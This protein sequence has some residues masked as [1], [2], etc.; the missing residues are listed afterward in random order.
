MNGRKIEGKEKNFIRDVS[1]S[2]ICI[3]LSHQLIITLANYFNIE[4]LITMRCTSLVPS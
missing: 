2:L 4:R 3:P 1:L